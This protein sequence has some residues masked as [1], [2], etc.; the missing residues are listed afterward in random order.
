MYLVQIQTYLYD[1]Y[2]AS[3]CISYKILTN[4]CYSWVLQ[5]NRDIE[6][7]E[8]QPAAPAP[9]LQLNLPDAGTLQHPV[10]QPAPAVRDVPK[11]AA[12][13]LHAGTDARS[14]ANGSGSS[15]RNGNSCGARARP[16]FRYGTLFC[17]FF[18]LA[19]RPTCMMIKITWW[20]Y[21]IFRGF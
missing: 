5:R 3:I 9:S 14:A 18:F 17:I 6:L 12:R 21:Q 1:T 8:W 20:K 2:L 13:L 16:K 7:A 10:P 4:V 19:N 11:S 15:G